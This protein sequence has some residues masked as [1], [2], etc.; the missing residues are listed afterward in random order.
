MASKTSAT[1]LVVATI[2]GLLITSMAL[3]QVPEANLACMLL[4]DDDQDG[5]NV[6]IYYTSTLDE[7]DVA[8]DVW[9]VATQG[10]PSADDLMGYQMVIWFTGYPRSDTFTSANETAVAA[11]LDAGGRSFFLSSEDY[12]YDMGLTMFGQIRLAISSYTNDVNRTDLEGTGQLP[13]G[14]SGAHNLVPPSGWVGDLYTD[15]VV[16][17][18]G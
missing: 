16:K 4:V 8:Y 18:G 2:W 6:R 11:Y 15:N 10:D 12:L 14:G 13:G 1:A 9:D 7:L 17:R 3:G 5:P